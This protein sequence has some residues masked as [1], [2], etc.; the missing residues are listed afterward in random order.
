MPRSRVGG[1]GSVEPTAADGGGGYGAPPTALP[2]REFPALE[3]IPIGKRSLLL[4]EEQ[5]PAGLVAGRGGELNL[6]GGE[7]G[8]GEVRKRRLNGVNGAIV[9]M[10]ASLLV[11]L[12]AAWCADVYRVARTCSQLSGSAAGCERE[13][14]RFDGGIACPACSTGS[15][16]FKKQ[17]TD[18]LLLRRKIVWK[19]NAFFMCF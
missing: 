15:R 8:G 16:S 13:N 5:H 4:P 7:G 18:P 11:C 10:V 3:R 9:C 1:R 2:D 6:E 12:H 19:C 17:M 14:P